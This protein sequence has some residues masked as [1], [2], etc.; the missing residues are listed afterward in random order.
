M[1]LNGMKISITD[2]KLPL[3]TLDHLSSVELET[4]AASGNQALEC[5]RVLKMSAATIVGEVL[6][7]QGEFYEWNHYPL[8]DV[9][10]WDSHS[11]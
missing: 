6:K 7:G 5:S 9:Y 8:G 3:V 4:M 2:L 11:Q 10:D 1:S